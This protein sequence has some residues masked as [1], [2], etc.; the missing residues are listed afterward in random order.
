MSTMPGSAGFKFKKQQVTV[1]ASKSKRRE[2]RAHGRRHV[3]VMQQASPRQR[4][5]GLGLG[6]PFGGI[7]V[8]NLTLR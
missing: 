4:N 3:I 7:L 1:T 5:G 8:L 2:S 6:T